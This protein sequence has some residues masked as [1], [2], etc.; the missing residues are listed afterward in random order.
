MSSVRDYVKNYGNISFKDKP[1]CDEDNVALC[2]SFY[3]PLDK[4]VSPSFDE[5][6]V[7][8]EKA[9]KDLSRCAA[10]SISPSVWCWSRVSAS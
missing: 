9:C 8:F 3:M 2:M 1:F 4:A 7:P 10:T 5:A 6:P